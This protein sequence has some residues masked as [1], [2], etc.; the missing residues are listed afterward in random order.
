MKLTTLI[1]L[2]LLSLSLP[3]ALQAEEDKDHEEHH[4][5][6]SSTEINRAMPMGSGMGM[7]SS[8]HEQMDKMH[9]QMDAIHKENEPEKRE[10][11]LNEHWKSMR[12]T[13][14][15]MRGMHRGGPKDSMPQRGGMGQHG[16]MSGMAGGPGKGPMMQP[17]KGQMMG[18][19][20]QGETSQTP[21]P[22]LDQMWEQHQQMQ[23]WMDSMGGL[24]EQMLEHQQQS[25][26]HPGGPNR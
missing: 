9:A 24:M 25:R 4:P 14:A 18:Q 1:T 7:M 13:M 15:M 22:T 20:A 11:L 26:R 2:S 10:Q 3:L 12:E 21:R 23:L 16:M 17:G 8:M 19:A 5:D 6:S